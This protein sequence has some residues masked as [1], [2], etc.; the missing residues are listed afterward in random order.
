MHSPSAYRQILSF[1]GIRKNEEENEKQR[2]KKSVVPAA[3]HLNKFNDFVR[4]YNSEFGS[5]LCG[6]GVLMQKARSL[7]T[8]LW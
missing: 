1:P 7:L 2:S 3:A 6:L 8:A 5:L 4:D